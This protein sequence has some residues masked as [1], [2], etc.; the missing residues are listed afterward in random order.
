MQGQETR[1]TCCK[2]AIGLTI[3]CYHI[4][5][6]SVKEYEKEK[7]KKD[8]NIGLTKF[9]GGGILGAIGFLSDSIGVSSHFGFSLLWLF[10]VGLLIGFWFATPHIRSGQ[11][12][13]RLPK[14]KNEAS[15]IGNNEIVGESENGKITTYQR[16]AACIYPNCTGRIVLTNAP[17]REISYLGKNFVGICS[18]SGRDHSYRID[19]VWNA[20][21]EKFDWRPLEANSK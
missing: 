13:G 14:N 1:L 7:L 11:I 19:Y 16:S 2:T 15:Y 17:Q 8:Q 3:L 5:E 18:L 4:D 21:P 12:L 9:V 20:Y 10:P 6:N